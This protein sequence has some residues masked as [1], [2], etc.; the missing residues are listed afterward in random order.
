[1]DELIETWKERITPCFVEYPFGICKKIYDDDGLLHSDE[2][3]ALITQN[4]ATWYSHGVK[5]GLQI[6]KNGKIEYFFRGIKIPD[7]IN[8]IFLNKRTLY[9]IMEGFIK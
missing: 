3:P 1:M 7:Y 2:E 4:T 9:H 8:P 6:T 5:H